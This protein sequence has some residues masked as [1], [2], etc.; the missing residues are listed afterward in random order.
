MTDFLPSH[1]CR[2]LVD[3]AKSSVI[4]RHFNYIQGTVSARRALPR[5]FVFFL[6]FG[7]SRFPAAGSF[8]PFGAKAAKTIRNEFPGASRPGGL[9]NPGRSRERVKLD[10]FSTILTLFVS[11]LTFWA[12]GPKGPGNSF[13]TLL[14]I[15]GPNGLNDPCAGQKF[16]RSF[17]S[18]QH[19]RH[20]NPRN[21]H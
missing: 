9:K 20:V 3:F 17:F 1:F 2:P 18:S 19:N 21:R 4:I 6:F 12:P 5:K 8:G 10:Y 7:D 16:S 13:R 11:F 14:A 15:L